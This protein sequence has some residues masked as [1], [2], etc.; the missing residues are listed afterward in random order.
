MML[1][2]SSRKAMSKSISIVDQVHLG[3]FVKIYFLDRY[4]GRCEK[5]AWLIFAYSRVH[6][7]HHRHNKNADHRTPII[8]RRS[9][10]LFF[11]RRE[12]MCTVKILHW[13]T[14]SFFTLR[15]TLCHQSVDPVRPRVCSPRTA[16]QT[17]SS[18]R[19]FRWNPNTPSEA[20]TACAGNCTPI[21]QD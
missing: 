7:A 20:H 21:N 15:C 17:H 18:A 16:L 8:G 13:R 9:S 1:I 19:R 12:V 14:V 10:L 4:T 3:N 5:C 2:W 6:L 11:A